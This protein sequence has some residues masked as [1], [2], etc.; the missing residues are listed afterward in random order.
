MKKNQ[1]L[2]TSSKGQTLV[3]ILVAIG[4]T[5][6]VLIAVFALAGRTINMGTLSRQKLQAINF[7]QE[8]MEAVRNIR[9]TNWI[10]A[11]KDD[12]ISWDDNIKGDFTDYGVQYN[13]T[14]EEWEIVSNPT[15]YDVFT[16]SIDIEDDPEVDGSEKKRITVTVSWGGGSNNITLYEDITNWKE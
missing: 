6:S 10:K 7:A 15:S 14:S 8:D 3:E 9:D 13:T 2:S 5:I 11:E 12:S 4:I 1:N 16:R